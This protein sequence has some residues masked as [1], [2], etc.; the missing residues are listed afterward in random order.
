MSRK[1]HIPQQ[2]RSRNLAALNQQLVRIGDRAKELHNKGQYQEA[3]DACFYALRLSDRCAPAWVDAAANCIYLNRFED[4][5]KYAQKGIS[6]GVSSIHVYDTLA[7]AHGVFR[8]WDEVK[9]Y[10]KKALEIRDKEFSRTVPDLNW[11]DLPPLPSADTQAQNIIAFSLFGSSPKYCETAILNA[12]EQVKIYPYWTCRFYI[13]DDVPQAVVQ[14]LKN[15]GAQVIVVEENTRKQL[16]GPMWRLLALG[17]TNLHRVM[18][19]DADSVITEFE[20]QATAEWLTSGK[21]FH[22]MR[23]S[24]THTELIL[25][26][27]WSVVS[28]SLPPLSNMLGEFLSKPLKSRHFADQYFLR[29]QVWPYA[30]LSLCAHD[31]LYDFMG[32]KLFPGDASFDDFV[33][34][35]QS[36]HVG[37]A[38][39]A[40]RFSALS[41]LPDGTDVE[42]TFF[43]RETTPEGETTEKPICTYPGKVL[44]GQV[45]DFLPNRY[46]KMIENKTA[47]IRVSKL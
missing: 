4:A 35:F 3:L 8:Q 42:W 10:G 1:P 2:N 18:F 32:G 31:S 43:V 46:A 45:A 47:V 21:R 9:K 30:R 41:D 14:R 40:V 39:G 5:I 38:E 29:E 27:L 13:A 26:G 11:G 15:A 44:D 36:F 37:Y 34:R 23:D 7:H 6:L 33:R 20:A 22:V 28:G 17:D 25:A 12:Q 16:P 19:R 24:A